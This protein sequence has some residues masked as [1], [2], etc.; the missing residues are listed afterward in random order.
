M[1]ETKNSGPADAARANAQTRMNAR[2]AE[3]ATNP[4]LSP[5]ELL[6]LLQLNIEYALA[7]RAALRAQ[8]AMYI[9][10]VIEEV[11]KRL[12]KGKDEAGAKVI[13]EGYMDG[14][15]TFD[16]VVGQAVMASMIGG[17]NE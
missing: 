10:P 1:N 14:K 7:F 2:W 3:A 6:G 13:V 11:V 17:E 12:S 15:L 4:N 5:V 16:Q 8:A 9:R